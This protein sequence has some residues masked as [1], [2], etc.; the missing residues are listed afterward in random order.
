MLLF[1]PEV[2]FCRIGSTQRRECQYLTKNCAEGRV[3]NPEGLRFENEAARHKALD[4]LGD[5]ALGGA[6]V[7]QYSGSKPGH[8]LNIALL[9]K[10]F[11]SPDNF[12][13]T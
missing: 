6:L 2:H 11:A 10:L 13:V 12:S 1:S 8:A 7:G 3:L 4:V 9:K 5:L